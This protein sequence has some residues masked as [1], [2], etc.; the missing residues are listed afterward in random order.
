V[1]DPVGETFRRTGERDIALGAGGAGVEGSE[2]RGQLFEDFGRSAAG[3]LNAPAFG[4]AGVRLLD[5]TSIQ[6]E[7]AFPG[8]PIT[9]TGDPARTEATAEAGR[10]AAGEGAEFAAENPGR[11]A[12][13]GAGA[14][15]G[16]FGAGAASRGI[17][18]GGRSAS[19]TTGSTVD[20]IAPERVPEPGTGGTGSVLDPSDIRQPRSRPTGTSGSGSTTG[21]VRADGGST[22][23]RVRAEFDDFLRDERGQVGTGRR[24]QRPDSDDVTP[25]PT[26]RDPSR[27]I[28]Q[29]S[30]RDRISGDITRRTRSDLEQG[31][32]TVDTTTDPIAPRG[33]DRGTA[34]G[35]RVPRDP[36]DTRGG[37]TPT[38]TDD[39]GAI[40]VGV[41]AGGV[42]QG[43]RSGA[44]DVLTGD[45]VEQGTRSGFDSGLGIDT[46]GTDLDGAS[47]VTI[48]D[49][50]ITG[51]GDDTGT[52]ATGGTGVGS[53]GT[54]RQTVRSTAGIGEI[55]PFAEAATP[56]DP[57]GSSEPARRSGEV[58]N[59][60]GPRPR[61]R[62]APGLPDLD[63]EDSEL[64]EIDVTGSGLI[65]E[66]ETETLDAIDD[67]LSDSL[68]GGDAP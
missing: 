7:P 53:R 27:E 12:A 51:T 8:G 67:E 14:I 60:A 32:G 56:S 38:G 13:I 2:A 28:V 55:D 6:A 4:A 31:R 47:G 50:T 3:A 9:L 45:A 48:A 26:S 20:D 54:G 64:Q 30:P 43:L 29:G 59:T 34:V 66:F 5:E 21:R 10:E 42:G 62:R 61:G 16:G 22:A 35:S 36:L 40:E 23:G 52:D 24:R 44:E 11:T 58:V 25:D 63:D 33:T 15:A 1:T 17:L 39:I 41:G 46:G 65:V 37:R 19:R 68:G 18:R 57:A 49:I